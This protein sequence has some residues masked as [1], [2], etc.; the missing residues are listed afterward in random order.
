[1]VSFFNGIIGRGGKNKMDKKTWINHLKGMF[2]RTYVEKIEMQSEDEK[3]IKLYTT[4]KFGGKYEISLDK[5]LWGNLKMVAYKEKLLYIYK[6]KNLL[7]TGDP[8]FIFCAYFE[9][10]G[11]E[12]NYFFDVE[13]VIEPHIECNEPQQLNDDE[14]NEIARIY[15]HLKEKLLSFPELRLKGLYQA[16]TFSWLRCPREFEKHFGIYDTI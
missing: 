11:V 16:K 14:I 6:M 13:E 10:K 4:H 5:N 7:D 12:I 15:E 9:I 1:M 2:E 3:S 8:S